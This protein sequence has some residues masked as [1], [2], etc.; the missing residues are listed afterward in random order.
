MKAS[1][2]TVPAMNLRKVLDEL[3]LTPYGVAQIIGAETDESIIT[4]QMRWSRWLKKTPGS[5]ATLERDLA[6]LGYRIEI[7]KKGQ[8]N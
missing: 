4:I 8:N 1:E 3:N 6:A 2:Q 7:K 5:I